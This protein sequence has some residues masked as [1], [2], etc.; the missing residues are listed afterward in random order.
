MNVENKQMFLYFSHLVEQ[1]L[2]VKLGNLTKDCKVN[3]PNQNKTTVK[4]KRNWNGLSHS[5][6]SLSSL[7]SLGQCG[8]ELSVIKHLNVGS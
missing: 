7:G 1:S 2:K 5:P 8:K 4:G 6:G 3:R